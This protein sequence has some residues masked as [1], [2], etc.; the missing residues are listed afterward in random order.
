MSAR[1]GFTLIELLVVISI[2]AILAVVGTIIYSIVQRNTR[3]ARR[4]IDVDAIAAALELNKQSI[5]IY[6][7]VQSLW[8]AS[9]S[10]PA[11]PRGPV[12]PPPPAGCGNPASTD[13]W[14]NG[15]WYCIQND[16]TTRDYCTINDWTVDSPQPFASYAQTGWV[17]CAN[18]ESGNPTYYCKG[19][20]Q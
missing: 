4:R 5:G 11:D 7:Q 10:I 8:F 13:G 17:V 16:S 20:S 18:L 15:C 6:Q 19:N 1:R 3:D 9:G 12:V 2:I 14:G